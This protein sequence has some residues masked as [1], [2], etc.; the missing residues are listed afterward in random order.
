M[1]IIRTLS[2]DDGFML[3]EVTAKIIEYYPRYRLNMDLQ[4]VR[5]IDASHN[6][7]HLLIC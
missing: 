5:T 4:F 6:E 1:T 3:V 7:N 2:S